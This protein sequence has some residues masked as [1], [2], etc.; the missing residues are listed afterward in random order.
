V[1][2]KVK[3]RKEKKF[4][5]DKIDDLLVE[6]T[7]GEKSLQSV[8]DGNEDLNGVRDESKTL[9]ESFTSIGR[10]NYVVGALLN[11]KIGDLLGPLDTNRGWALIKVKG[12]A[13][14]DSTDY[15]VQKDVL[16]TNLFNREQNQVFQSWLE[17][18]KSRAEIVDNR[19]YIF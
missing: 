17:D 16:K 5:R 3:Q 13:P 1:S 6:I 8:M 10:S 18:L 4:S 11:S 19:K 2:R 12:I 15:E 7:A 9:L 14:I